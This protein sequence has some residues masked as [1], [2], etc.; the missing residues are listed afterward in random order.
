LIR[1]KKNE[2]PLLRTFEK[3]SWDLAAGK[4][5]IRAIVKPSPGGKK[6]A[7]LTVSR[8]LEK[9]G[10]GRDKEPGGPQKGKGQRWGL[11]QE[12]KTQRTPLQG[13]EASGTKRGGNHLHG[14]EGESPGRLGSEIRPRA[15]RT[16]GRRRDWPGRG[17]GEK[18]LQGIFREKARPLIS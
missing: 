7:H 17:R 16:Q 4:G 11:R 5:N 14:H 6:K 12:A 2:S 8:V 3:K 15:L 10:G 1:E 9:G 18:V 13:K